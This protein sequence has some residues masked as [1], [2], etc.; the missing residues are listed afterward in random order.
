MRRDSRKTSAAFTLI[1]LLVVV[2]IIAL[3]ISILL[4][5]LQRARE[6]AKSVKC[7]SN[8]KMLGQ[9]VITYASECNDGLPGP[10]HPAVYRDQGIEALTNPTNGLPSRAYGWARYQQT[11]YLTFRLRAVFSDTETMANSISDEV[12]RCPIMD[13]VNPDSNF[14]AFYQ[15]TSK[16]AYPTSYVIN[17]V[18]ANDQSGSPVGGMRATDPL[19]YFGYSPHTPNVPALEALARRHP[20]QKLT[21]IQRSAEEWMIADAWYRKRP[22]T[23][24]PELQQEGP[25]QWD[26]TGEALPNFAPHFSRKVYDFVSPEERNAQSIRIR[27]GR[28]DGETNT[29]FFDGHA[30]PVASK[31]LIYMG[32]WELLYGFRG[33]VNPETPIPDDAV[34]K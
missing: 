18:G 9:G 7:L 1:E 26:W 34:W 25:Y 11:R 4:P 22:S 23:M 31:T 6:Q 21:K 5:S 30:R 33:T 15:S 27:D 29:V 28:E 14:V 8:L 12:S 19:N 13:Q 17:N 3:L 20:P 32:G 16:L 10:L 2:A 24:F